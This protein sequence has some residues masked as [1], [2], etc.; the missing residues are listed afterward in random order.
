MRPL[1]CPGVLQR[2]TR[3]STRRL[4]QSCRGFPPC[5]TSES[6]TTVRCHECFRVRSRWGG[7]RCR[8]CARRSHWRPRRPRSSRWHRRGLRWERCATGRLAGRLHSVCD[9][10]FI[11]LLRTFGNFRYDKTWFSVDFFIKCFVFRANFH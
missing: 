6:S 8:K 2:C 11:S 1:Q 3:C 4:H 5:K 7:S 10:C 9:K